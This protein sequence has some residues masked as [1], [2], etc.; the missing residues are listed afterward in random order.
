ML[1]RDLEQVVEVEHTPLALIQ[2]T[3]VLRRPA[4]AE[5]TSQCR[6]EARL[7]RRLGA[8][9]ADLPYEVAVHD[10]LEKAAVR[11]WIGSDRRAGDRHKP[12]PWVD[13]G[14]RSA[15]LVCEPLSVG[16]AAE[17]SRDLSAQCQPLLG[18]NGRHL[19]SA[20]LRAG[21]GKHERLDIGI[22]AS[23]PPGANGDARLE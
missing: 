8:D 21:V 16:L 12:A 9:Q 23:D 2:L 6:G 18:V 19:R 20:A 11:I 7:P 10:W 14:V 13:G 5:V 3:A 15:D 4:G 1:A 17:H 22:Q